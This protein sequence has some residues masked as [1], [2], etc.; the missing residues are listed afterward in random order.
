MQLSL[1]LLRFSIFGYAPFL[2]RAFSVSIWAWISSVQYLQKSAKLPISNF[3][4]SHCIFDFFCCFNIPV[5]ESEA[6]EGKDIK[7]QILL[8]INISEANGCQKPPLLFIW[9]YM[10]RSQDSLGWKIPPSGPRPFLEQEWLQGC[11]RL[12]RVLCSWVS[13]IFKCGESITLLG[14]LCQLFTPLTLWAVFS[15]Y[16]VRT[17][18]AA[19]CGIWLRCFM[20]H[21]TN[22]L[23]K[24]LKGKGFLS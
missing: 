7:Q 15:L 11:L 17:V 14:N 12:L 6:K 8:T 4:R 5:L 21:K 1:L 22:I 18:F 20:L 3:K 2:F 19:A 23:V 16:P 9:T 13:N 10:R 24:H